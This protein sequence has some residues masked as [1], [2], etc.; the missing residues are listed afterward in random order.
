LGS[1]GR[2]AMP[3]ASLE[4]GSEEKMGKLSDRDVDFRLKI[5]AAKSS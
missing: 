3:A 2:I 5:A 4:V 1:A